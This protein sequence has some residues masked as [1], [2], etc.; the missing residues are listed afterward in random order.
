MKIKT[1]NDVVPYLDMFYFMADNDLKSQPPYKDKYGTEYKVYSA[2]VDERMFK[3]PEKILAKMMISHFMSEIYYCN[4]LYEHEN[5]DK[6]Q[7]VIEWRT[8]PE[9]TENT[10][11]FY[12]R[13]YARYSI[14]PREKK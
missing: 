1:I 8:R 5:E 14:Y 11:H 10:K 9:Y 2:V 4:W 3:N 13:S 7:W 12:A 6:S